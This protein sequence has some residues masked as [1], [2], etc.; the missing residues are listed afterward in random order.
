MRCCRSIQFPTGSTNRCRRRRGKWVPYDR[1]LDPSEGAVCH[2]AAA[3]PRGVVVGAGVARLLAG[4]GDPRLFPGP[5]IVWAAA[6]AAGVYPRRARARLWRRLFAGAGDSVPRP[7]GAGRQCRTAPHRARERIAASAAAGALRPAERAA[8][9][10]GGG[11]VG[12]APGA[13]DRGGAPIAGWAA[14]RRP[15]RSRSMGRARGAGDIAVARRDR[16]RRRLAR[17]AAAAR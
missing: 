3:R 10:A 1:P 11:V 15:R 13:N 17:A 5:R 6:D 12:G 2:A 9:P 4:A 7:L 14:G 8:R 16:R